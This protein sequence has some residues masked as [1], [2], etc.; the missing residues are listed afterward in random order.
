MSSPTLYD[1]VIV[2]K[3]TPD[4]L[5]R[6]QSGEIT[7][8]AKRPVVTGGFFKVS[9][10]VAWTNTI[11]K[12]LVS[13]LGIVHACNHIIKVWRQVDNMGNTRCV[14][15]G[16]LSNFIHFEPDTLDSL[17]NEWHYYDSEDEEESGEDGQ[18]WSWN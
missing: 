3:L 15:A 11:W 13:Y 5:E 9:E 1:A 18:D 12:E 4:E 6:I 17:F 2:E 16:D 10:L 7:E 14:Y 8:I